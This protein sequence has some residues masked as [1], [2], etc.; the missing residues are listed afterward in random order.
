MKAHV[1]DGTYVR[2]DYRALSTDVWDQ[3]DQ[4][5]GSPHYATYTTERKDG[6]VAAT[7]C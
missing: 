6:H 4:D 1:E 2:T 5:T 7:Y 3:L